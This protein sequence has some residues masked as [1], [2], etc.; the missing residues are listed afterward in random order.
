MKKRCF[1]ILT[2]VC[3][4]ALVAFGQSKKR[5]AAPS[6]SPSP[7]DRWAE[8]QEVKWQK[9]PST[10]TLGSTAQVQVPTGYV[11][12]GANDA[13]TLMEIF[14]NPTTGKEMG[15]VAPAGEVWFAVFE[16]DDVGYVADDDKHALDT[17][18]LLESI[19]EGTA[20]SNKERL[21]R[22]W[23]AVTILGWE[24]PPHYDESTHNLEWAVRVQSDGAPVVNY[25][26][27][28]LGRGGVMEVTL[29]ADSGTLGET[30]PKFKTML[31][32]FDF[33]Q[34]HKYAEF[35]AGDKKAAYGLAGLVVGGTTAVLVK[36]GAFKWV[37]K[38]LVAAGVGVAALVKKF[39][40]REKTV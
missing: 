22:G 36:S 13:R 25:N 9:G 8:F 24:Q 38:A 21:R 5:R 39:F 6:P 16:Y 26:T 20:E 7:E 35:R 17:D 4:C 18:A 14:R 30:L 29:V 37:W 31:S 2:I 33:N 23:P 15:F 34:G 40:S 19:K 12:A 32:G 3:I 27:R 1:I 10:G 28:L 11:F